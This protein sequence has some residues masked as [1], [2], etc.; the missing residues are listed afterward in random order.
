MRSY[1]LHLLRHGLTQ[2][3][4][5]G[6]F[7]GGGLDIPLCD[8]GKEG[9]RALR[10]QYSYPDVPLLF[11]SPMRRAL[12]SADLLY[13]EVKERIVLEELRENRFG[14]F[15]GKSAAELT[16]DERF[17]AWL[18][19]QSGFVPEGG[20][21]GEAFARRTAAALLLMMNHLAQ[22]GI[23]EAACVTH[24]GVIMAMLGQRGLPQKPPRGWMSDNGCGYT[25][26]ADAGMLMRDGLVEVTEVL[27]RG[28]LGR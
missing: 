26:Q 17:A 11:S 5:E 18:D 15:E 19:P 12:E 24:G 28:Y 8:E 7:V 1:K 23:A 10:K 21:S 4:K 20:E 13:P 22:N 2:G 16:E 6:I 3:N 14:E 9:L 27:P 25:V